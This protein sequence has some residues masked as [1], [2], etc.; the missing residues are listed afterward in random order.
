MDIH[1]VLVGLEGKY[2]ANSNLQKGNTQSIHRH[3]SKF[4]GS[5]PKISIDVHR[6][7]R[8]NNWAVKQGST[9]F[10]LLAVDDLIGD[11]SRF[12]RSSDLSRE[13]SGGISIAGGKVNLTNCAT[14][15]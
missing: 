3:L 4:G 7:S 14:L 9:R 8:A 1:Q 13:P 11:G 5:A 10:V 12:G 15:I 6:S 2:E